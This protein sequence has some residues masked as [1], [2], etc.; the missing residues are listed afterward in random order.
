MMG[1]DEHNPAG[2]S[3]VS[4]I[5][6]ESSSSAENKRL[7]QCSSLNSIFHYPNIIPTSAS[8]AQHL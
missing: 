7:A 1:G 4:V 6:C 8:L 3:I 2:E 5:D